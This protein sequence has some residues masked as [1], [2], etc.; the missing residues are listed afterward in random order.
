MRLP[1]CLWSDSTDE[2]RQH[3]EYAPDP[4]MQPLPKDIAGKIAHAEQLKVDGN[5]HFKA[6]EVK[7][8]IHCYQQVRAPFL[9]SRLRYHT[10]PTSACADRVVYHG[11]PVRWRK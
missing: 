9:S 1:N 10:G 5:Q 2:R 7:K 8:A 4:I 3:A 6:Q 11:P